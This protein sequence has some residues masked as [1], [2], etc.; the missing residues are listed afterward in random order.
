MTEEKAKQP[1]GIDFGG[2]KI[3]LP[4]IDGKR[5]DYK[6]AV[7]WIARQAKEEETKVAIYHEI[8]CSPLDGAVAFKRAL[9]HIYGWTNLVPTPGFFGPTPPAMLGV[10]TGSNGEMEQVPWGSIKAPGIDGTFETGFKMKPPTF[11]ISGEVKRKHEHQVAAV[12][13]MTKRFVSE[14]SI[15]KG[16]AVK[17]SFEWERNTNKRTGEAEYDPFANAPQFMELDP[18]LETTLIFGDRVAR[19]LEIGL[20][21]AIEQNEA[22]RRYKV[23]LKRGVLLY[24]P[25]G[26]GKTLTANITALKATRNKWT[27]IYLSDVRDLKRGLEF[28]ARYA[29]A[30]LFAEDI[31]RMVTGERSSEM[32]EILNTLDGVD[33]KN[34][35]VITV[36]TTNHVNNINPAMLRMGRLDA[37]VEIAPPDAEAARRLVRL[38]ARGLLEPSANLEKVGERLNGKIPAFIRE[39]TERAKIAAIYR[40]KGGDIEGHV[41]EED[42]IAASYAMESHEAFLKPKAK[43]EAKRR[44]TISLPADHYA[45]AD[46]LESVDSDDDVQVDA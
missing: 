41:T 27:F 8:I 39:V 14:R 20:F 45:V 2:T 24:G 18:S 19:E 30:V 25:Y 42:L 38:Y 17:V 33:T 11:V 4:E 44:V 29:P 32:D 10:P 5:M 31:D 16:K 36:F 40:L 37:L 46:L 7:E 26:T 12:V 35:E 28:A 13:E 22:C 23:P 15:Y 21:T 43:T 6:E 1:V 9:A 34:G 3:V